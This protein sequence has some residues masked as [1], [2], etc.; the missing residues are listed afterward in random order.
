M[1]HGWRMSRLVLVFVLVQGLLWPGPAVGSLIIPATLAELAEE[2]WAIVHGRVTAVRPQWTAGRRGIESLVTVAVSDYLKGDLGPTVTVRTPGGTLGAYRTVL[3][4]APVFR[5]GD[6]VV[7]FLATHG[8]SIPFILGL[9]QGAY[10]VVPQ[11]G[12][13]RRVVKPALFDATAAAQ[14]L[15][16]GDPGRGSV[17]LQEFSDRLRQVVADLP[18]GGRQR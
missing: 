2:A 9:G 16:R 12:T 5:E 4:G 1:A 7:L 18:S 14:R 3:V 10:R 6:E 11:P 13:G 15:V 17:P 8:P